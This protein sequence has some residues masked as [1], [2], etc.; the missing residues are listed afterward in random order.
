MTVC[1]SALCPQARGGGGVLPQ[2]GPLSPGPLSPPGSGQRSLRKRRLGEAGVVLKEEQ[3]K[4]A[5]NK[6]IP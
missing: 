1:C 3:T 5:R 2:S 4:A 6:S